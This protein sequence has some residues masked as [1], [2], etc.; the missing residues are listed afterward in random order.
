MI[1]KIAAALHVV[2]SC[3]NAL[4]PSILNGS[5]SDEA[6][7]MDRVEMA[8]HHDAR[9]LLF[10]GRARQQTIA[11]TVSGPSCPAGAISDAPRPASDFD[12]AANAVED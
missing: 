7:R 5:R 9:R 3:P 8:R 12:Q 11:A 6:D 10:P 2:D 1:G 4:S